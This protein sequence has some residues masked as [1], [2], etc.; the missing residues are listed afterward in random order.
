VSDHL[1]RLAAKLANFNTD[2]STKVRTQKGLDRMV[3]EGKL[4]YSRC[5]N[6]WTGR[7]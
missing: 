7:Q 3:R 2:V 4:A 5:H 1:D 6:Y